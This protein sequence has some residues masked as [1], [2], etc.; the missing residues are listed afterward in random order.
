MRT[1]GRALPVMQGSR[2]FLLFA[3]VLVAFGFMTAG[4]VAAPT[5]VKDLY[6]GA[7]DGFPVG[8]NMATATKFP[9]RWTAPH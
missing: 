7:E 4:A 9:L 3:A 8:A 1:D 2:S 5:L 6:Q